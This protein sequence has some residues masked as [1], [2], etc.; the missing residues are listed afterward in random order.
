MGFE[1]GKEV[2]C[3]DNSG[4]EFTGLKEGQTYTVVSI[5]KFCSCSPFH[6]SI[7]SMC[8]GESGIDVQAGQICS[9]SRC[10]KN[11]I[12]DGLHYFFPKRFVPLDDIT[13]SELTEVLEKEPFSI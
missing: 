11:Y 10:D 4:V 8:I 5:K 12:S 13:I 7:G 2:V 1:V 6:V 3:V 9:C